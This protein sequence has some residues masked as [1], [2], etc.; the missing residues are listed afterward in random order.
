MTIF[1]TTI[2]LLRASKGHTK[3]IL[4][5]CN[6]YDKHFYYCNHL[7]CLDKAAQIGKKMQKGDFD[8]DDFI[9]QSQSVRKMGGMGGMLKMMPGMA[10]KITDEMLFEAEKRLKQSELIVGV[11]TEVSICAV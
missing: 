2:L 6:K 1:N 3:C 7:S 5:Q 11:M 4:L 9:L 10:G 8:F